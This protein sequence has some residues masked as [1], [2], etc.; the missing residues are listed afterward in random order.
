MN[1][2]AILRLEIRHMMSDEF[3]NA[4]LHEWQKSTVTYLGL[5]PKT[6]ENRLKKASDDLCGALPPERVR[7]FREWETDWFAHLRR[8]A[9]LSFRTGT[10]L[11]FEEY[12]TGSREKKPFAYR[13]WEPLH[14]EVREG[15]PENG[16]S[17]LAFF[18]SLRWLFD[19]M[20]QDEKL[21]A[22]DGALRWLNR[23]WW[24]RERGTTGGA[25][26]LGYYYGTILSMG[27][28]VERSRMQAIREETGFDGVFRPEAVPVR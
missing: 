9:L 18:D 14:P 28:K 1:E 26:Y 22:V 19:V 5:R 20:H 24:A 13:V 2:D 15:Y 11:Y 23:G 8:S 12:Y 6:W 25:F 4:L 10:A 27:C 7:M 3:L 17:Q 21:R 16:H